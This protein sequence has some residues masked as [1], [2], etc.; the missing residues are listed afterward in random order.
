[1]KILLVLALLLAVVGFVIFVGLALVG[2]VVGTA[3]KAWHA[4]KER[5]DD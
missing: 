2:A 4:G 5:H 3:S 1:M